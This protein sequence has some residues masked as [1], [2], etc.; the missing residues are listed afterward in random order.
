MERTLLCA[1]AR[2][3][4]IACSDRSRGYTNCKAGGGKFGQILI[5]TAIKWAKRGQSMSVDPPLVCVM[6]CRTFHVTTKLEQ[7]QGQMDCRWYKC[8]QFVVTFQSIAN[9]PGYWRR[10][11]YLW[12]NIGGLD[13]GVYMLYRTSLA[14]SRL[15]RWRRDAARTQK[16]AKVN[17]ILI[18]NGDNGPKALFT[19]AVKINAFL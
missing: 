12:I 16:I 9:I 6:L 10:G 14:F 7:G 13:A 1:K 18:N 4:R 15:I 5:K 19:L 11:N 2:N 8:V 17:V 3:M